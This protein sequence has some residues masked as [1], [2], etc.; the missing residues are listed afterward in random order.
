VPDAT[1][2]TDEMTQDGLFEYFFG[3]LP[4]NMPENVVIT[5]FFSHKRFHGYCETVLEFKGKAYSGALCARDGK[6][7]A[8]VTSGLGPGLAG[9]SV[10]LL[11]RAGARKII[12]AG[13]CGGLC[14]TGIGDIIV[15]AE[16]V[17]GEGVSK[18]YSGKHGFKDILDKADAVRPDEALSRELE[19]QIKNLAAPGVTVKKGKILTIGSLTAET[20]ANIQELE[21]RGY[22]G[23]DM[24]TSAVLQTAR[25]LNVPCAAVLFVSDMPSSKPFW[26][27]MEKCDKRKYN[28]SVDIA[29]NSCVETVAK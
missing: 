26:K 22:S 19:G 13:S 4:E 14:G 7:F 18:Y 29:L 27:D 25:S 8:V 11:C 21:K 2:E 23:I 6:N 3:I 28:D 15:C 1:A 12:F 5:P 10:V 16:A 17:D 20:P 24:E 9:D